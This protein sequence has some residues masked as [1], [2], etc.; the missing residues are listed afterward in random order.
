MPGLFDLLTEKRSTEERA[1]EIQSS[2]LEYYQLIKECRIKAYNTNTQ[3]CDTIEMNLY[4]GK[5]NIL[6]KCSDCNGY[7]WDEQ[8]LI[9]APALILKDEVRITQEIREQIAT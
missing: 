2:L 5:V 6:C 4:N 3:E 8:Y 1:I 7:K 9:S